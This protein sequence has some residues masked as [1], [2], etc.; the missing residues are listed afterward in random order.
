MMLNM[1]FAPLLLCAQLLFGLDVP[2][3]VRETAGVARTAEPVTFG[4]PLPRKLLTETGKLRLYDPRGESVPADFRV[5]NR[6]W[7][8]AASQVASI[9]WVH[10]NF[11]PSAPARGQTVYH[12]RT[13]DETAP[14]P[15]S[16][17]E[18][19]RNGDDLIVST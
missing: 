2:I 9:Q 5:V 4:V 16:K 6:W 14:A 13:S 3:T 8:D 11:F 19:T 15:S 1:T 17:L 10:C 18:V 12:L 7:D